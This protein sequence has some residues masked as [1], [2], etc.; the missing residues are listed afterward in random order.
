M[1]AVTIK[2]IRSNADLEATKVRLAHLLSQSGGH[3][4]DDEIEV[5]ATLV[6]QFEARHA[7]I[8]APDPISAI[9]YRMAEKG[10]SPRHLEP[11]IG[12]RARVSEILTGK[13]TLSL[14]MIRSLHDGLGIP[15]ESL[16]TV[17]AKSGTVED[18]SRGTIDRLN[19]RGFNFDRVELPALISSSLTAAPP[20]TVLLRKT[21]TQR[22]AL[23]MDQDALLIWQAAV[24]QKA[25]SIYLANKFDAARFYAADLRQLAKTSA[26]TGAVRRAVEALTQHGIVL[27]VMESLPGIF[28]DGAAMVR[29]DGTPVI[30]LTLRHSRIDNFWF[31]LLHEASHIC[32]HYAFLIE[33]RSAFVDDMDIVSEDVREQEAD[34]LA[35]DS[36][37][38]PSFL[39]QVEW[40]DASSYEDLETLAAR[41]RVPLPV[42]AGRWQ[43]DHQNYKKFARLIDRTSVRSSLEAAGVG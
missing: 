10:L 35:R 13:R 38:P 21:R 34:A 16:L 42:V 11:F 7:P 23:K 40:S 25:D 18:I 41:A 2:P 8:D 17:P 39:E 43:R 14:D 6:E 19:R 9:K 30:G 28:L 26:K 5:L 33:T 1:S 31:T 36:L 4:C 27:V 29:A 20:P 15:Y 3:D 37:I 32:L 22:A 12:S 24:L